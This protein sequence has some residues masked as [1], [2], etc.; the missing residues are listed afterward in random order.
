[1]GSA[2]RMS[3]MQRPGRGAWRLQLWRQGFLA[4]F[5]LATIVATHGSSESTMWVPGCHPAQRQGGPVPRAVGGGRVTAPR[6]VRA[7]LRGVHPA[8]A[9]TGLRS[10]LWFW[11]CR[12]AAAILAGSAVLGRL[13]ALLRRGLPPHGVCSCVVYPVECTCA[14]R[15]SACSPCSPPFYRCCM[16]RLPPVALSLARF[17]PCALLAATPPW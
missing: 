9:L 10:L 3:R 4:G 17:G 12:A 13:R 7:C 5:A 1:M 11:D 15:A 16:H 6:M 8:S 2:G 14:P